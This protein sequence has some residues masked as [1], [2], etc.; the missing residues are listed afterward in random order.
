ML[1]FRAV[2]LTGWFWLFCLFSFLAGVLFEQFNGESVLSSSEL[3]QTGPL[4][5]P[6]A[7]LW[8]RYL[9]RCFGVLR[10]IW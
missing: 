3:Y 8:V 1:L 6:E 4:R 10:S 7:W 5:R 2:G 9:F